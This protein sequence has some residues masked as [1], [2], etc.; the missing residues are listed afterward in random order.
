MALRIAVAVAA[1]FQ[2][3]VIC[4]LLRKMPGVEVVADATVLGAIGRLDAVNFLLADVALCALEPDLFADLG[5]RLQGRILLLAG[6]DAGVAFQVPSGVPVLAREDQASP[7]KLSAALR[8]RLAAWI[9]TGGLTRGIATKRVAD[10]VPRGFTLTPA[11]PSSPAGPRGQSTRVRRP[12][13]IVVAASTGGPDALQELFT[14]LHPPPCPVVIALHIPAEHAEGLVRHIG[15]VTGHRIGVGSA[16]VPLANEVVLLPGGVD[17]RLVRGAS[18]LR[19]QSVPGS[20]SVFRPNADILFSSASE[21]DLAVTGVVLTGMGDDGSKGAQ[22]LVAQGN[23]IL[24][25]SPGSCAVP[26]MPSACMA[27]CRVH[28]VATPVITHPL[29]MDSNL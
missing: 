9:S 23:P 15:T 18:G 14:A 17:H 2:R 29:A 22:A 11:A 10:P 27:A 3:I 16:G 1:D 20:A 8:G 13:L 25:Q 6:A 21:L 28:S 26:G 4:Q 5:K 7:A 24:V 19:L 12:A